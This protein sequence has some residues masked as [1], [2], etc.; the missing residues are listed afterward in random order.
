MRSLPRCINTAA[1]TYQLIVVN[2]SHFLP[3]FAEGRQL[4]LEGPTFLVSIKPNDIKNAIKGLIAPTRK[5]VLNPYMSPNDPRIP[6]AIVVPISSP[7]AMPIAVV[8]AAIAGG[9]DSWHMMA[10]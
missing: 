7:M 1:L 2:A 6:G 9:T 10:T 8:V 5:I 3:A 4:Q